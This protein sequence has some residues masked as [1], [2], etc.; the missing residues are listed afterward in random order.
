MKPD[1]LRAALYMLAGMAAFTFSDA[2]VKLLLA[3][4]TLHQVFLLRGVLASLLLVALCRGQRVWPVRVAPG[5]GRAVG[6]RT[7]GEVAAAICFTL[8]LQRMPLA[9]L[10]AILQSV[11]LAVTLAAAAVFGE[12]LG[13]R[14]LAAIGL[15]F[16]G[17]LLI[18]RPGTD[19]FNPA[20]LMALATV[21]WVVLR[22]LSTRAVS[23]GT[24][25]LGLVLIGSLAVTATGGV[26]ALAGGWQPVAAGHLGL[27]ALSAVCVV[28]GY[29]GV[30]LAVRGGE[31]GAIAPF[32]YSG[33]V[34]AM[35]LGWL[36]FGD[37]PRPLTLLGAAIVVG[38]GLFTFY[39]ERRLAREGRIPRP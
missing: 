3:D 17:V 24:P 1:N 33:L 10:T 16:C 7:L 8:A 12:R 28:G 26:G 5:D 9:S 34:W 11:P 38:T 4:L 18:V 25:T 22:D 39:R 2:A 13:W 15:G 35:L 19:G 6:L 31:M 29:V 27:L 20:A 37:F 14:R 32:R 21:G 36:V 23:A 30:V